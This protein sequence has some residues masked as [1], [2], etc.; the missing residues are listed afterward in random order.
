MRNIVFILKFLHNLLGRKLLFW[1]FLAVCAAVSEGIGVALFLPILEGGDPEG[2]IAEPV[3]ET[4]AE[5]GLEYSVLTLLIVMVLFFMLRG[6]LFV[7]Q[8]LYFK[9][10]ISRCFVELRC[11]FITRFF[12]V[13]YQYFLRKDIGSITNAAIV[14]LPRVLGAFEQCVIVIVS[15]GLFVVYCTLPLSLNPYLTLSVV[16]LLIPGYFI[17]SKINRMTQKLSIENSENNSRLQSFLIQAFQH[18][19]YL[20]A[21]NSITGIFG[22][23]RGASGVQGR[24]YYKLAVMQSF[25]SHSVEPL[26]VVVIAGLFFYHVQIRGGDIIEMVFVAFLIR[27]AITFFFVAQQS[28]RK[29]IAYTGSIRIFQK[30]KEEL[31]ENQ[32][33]FK[34]DAIAPNFNQSI[35][36]QDVSFKYGDGPDVLKRIN[37]DIL[38]KQTVAFVGRSGAGKS[39]LATLLTGMLKPKSGQVLLGNTCY[40]NIDYELIRRDIGY[41]TQEG[42]I[43]NDTIWNNI[44][45]WEGGVREG[46]VHRAAAGAHIDQFIED[47]PDRYDAFLGDNGINISGGQRQRISI[48]RE[49]FKEAQLVIFDEATSSLDGHSEREIQKNIDEF[50]GV[51]TII[52][53]AHRLS[54]VRRSDLIV[55]LKDGEI[56]EQGTYD[57]LY[58]LN[59]EFRVMVQEQALSD[60]SQ[61]SSRKP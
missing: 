48:A 14:E 60:T 34:K 4:L 18:F 54:T 13:D 1:L 3:A 55:V 2:K 61:R 40:S 26:S 51:K 46:Q 39:T 47:L 9:K 38:P 33:D 23:I 53:I 30:F 10:I 28:Y 22:K 20:K 5:F 12:R 58:D 59:G 42:V 32:E 41:V 15:V 44:T 17:F 43:F 36:L 45:L 27:R 49:L 6:V 29:V 57:E 8:D 16:V 21:T 37:L 11:D 19:K 31:A 7:F 24:I 25:N 50:R 56:V 52:I 35:R